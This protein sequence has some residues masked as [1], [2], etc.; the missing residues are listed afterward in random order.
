MFGLASLASGSGEGNT[1]HPPAQ[2][3]L[4]TVQQSERELEKREK[5]REG[6]RRRERELDRG[7]VEEREER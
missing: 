1:P 4:K 3:W 7:R 6:E 5:E 2:P